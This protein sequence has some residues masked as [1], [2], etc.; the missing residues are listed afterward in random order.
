MYID[1]RLSEWLDYIFSKRHQQSIS[2]SG[3]NC[4]FKSNTQYLF[5]AQNCTYFAFSQYILDFSHHDKLDFFTFHH[6]SSPF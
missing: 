4:F 2:K 5:M 3:Q 6:N 1:C